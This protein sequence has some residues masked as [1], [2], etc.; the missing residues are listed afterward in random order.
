MNLGRH[1]DFDSIIARY[2]RIRGRVT[3]SRLVLPAV[4]LLVVVGVVWSWQR[5]DLDYT[6]LGWGGLAAS[7]ALAIPAAMLSAAEFWLAQRLAGGHA[8]PRDSIRV[9]LL[10]SLGNLL[11]IPGGAIVRVEAMTARGAAPGVAVRTTGGIGLAWVGL[12]LVASGLAVAAAGRTF[13]GVAAAAAGLV[14]CIAGVVALRPR[15]GTSTRVVGAVFLLETMVIVLATWRIHIVLSAIGTEASWTQSF[16]LV[17]SGALAVS[18]GL[19][20]AGLGVREL[21]ASILAP[22]VGLSAAAGFLTAGLNQVLSLLGQGALALTTIR[23]DRRGTESKESM[24]LPS[25]TD[26]D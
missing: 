23:P 8:T 12:T 25:L 1:I 4:A 3:K 9:S 17:A 6:T 24:P 13:P 2:Q 11:P 15:G 7:A 20:P 14:V 16:G 18:V 26:D 22:L 19:V 21:L 10:G 5:L